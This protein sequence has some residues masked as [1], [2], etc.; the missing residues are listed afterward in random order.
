MHCEKIAVRGLGASRFLEVFDAHYRYSSSS[1]SFFNQRNS[2]KDVAC[3]S[4]RCAYREKFEQWL[5]QEKM[6]P[7]KIME[8]GTIDGIIGCVAAGLGISM[9]PQSVITKHI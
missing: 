4:F 7:N 1:K 5:Y 3:I 6:I 9:L 8:F 2:N